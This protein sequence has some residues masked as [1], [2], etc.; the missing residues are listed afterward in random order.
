MKTINHPDFNQPMTYT[1]MPLPEDSADGQ[2]AATIQVMRRYS[3]EDA[4]SS[5]EQSLSQRLLE[6]CNTPQDYLQAVFNEAKRRMYFQQ[7]EATASPIGEAVELLIRPVD[8][9]TLSDSG[10]TV[11]GDCDCFSMLVA[12]LLLAG[13]VDCAFATVG[14]D[15]SNP[16]VFS[17]VYVV[18]WPGT[19]YRTVIDAS[20]GPSVNWEAPNCGRY[21]EWPLNGPAG[22]ASMGI[23]LTALMF[24]AGY[25]YLTGKLGE[26]RNASF[27]S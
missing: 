8:V 5:S 7:D 13:G 26:R 20:H 17:H 1:V 4:C 27:A 10:Q 12:S 16:D 3:K 15:K 19:E 2:V 6:N 21:Q 25:L 14:A 22:S 18:A 23:I 9:I 11:P 24:V